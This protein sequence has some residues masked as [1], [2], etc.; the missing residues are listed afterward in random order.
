MRIAHV[1]FRAERPRGGAERYAIDLSNE[2]IRRGHR[3]DLLA[4]KFADIGAAEPVPINARGLT[5]AARYQRFIDEV[6]RHLDATRY[7]AVHAHLPVRS[8]DVYTTHSGLEVLA[9]RDAHRVKPTA[10]AQLVAMAGNRLSVKRRRVAQVEAELLRNSRPPIT[11][12]LSD[13]EREQAAALFPESAR[14]MVTLYSLPDD[15][16][17]DPSQLADRRKTMRKIMGVGADQPTFV[18]VGQDFQRKGLATAIAALG[19]VR[20]P[21]ALLYVLGDGDVKAYSRLALRAG[22]VGRV[23]FVGSVPNVADYLAAA[24][25]LVLPTRFEPFGMVVVEAIL[26]GCPPIVSKAAGASEVV[27]HD[28]TGYQIGDYD[29]AAGFAEAMDRLSDPDASERLRKAC[30]GER[31]RFSYARQVDQIEALY[32]Q[33]RS[34]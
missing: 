34:G 12:C 15:R 13:R 33:S 21:H 14:R 32:R 2:L 5:R 31:D 28:R 29:D 9:L 26:M 24:D 1:I 27:G 4:S 19:R 10:A 8:C 22:V 3:V 23:L 18:F 30:L 11:I 20:N 16:R 17:F 7:D 6:Q 25:G